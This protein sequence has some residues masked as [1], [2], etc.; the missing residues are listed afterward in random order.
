[1]TILLT[2][3][4]KKSMKYLILL[5]FLSQPLMT[6]PIFYDD[7]TNFPDGWTLY[8]NYGF[9][10]VMRPEGHSSP[11]CS[12][13]CCSTDYY[14]HGEDIYMERSIDLSNCLSASL[15]FWWMVMTE[16]T[17]DFVEL[18]YYTSSWIGAWRESGNYGYSWFQRTV[19][20]PVDATAIRFWFWSDYSAYGHGVFIDDVLLDAA[21]IGIEESNRRSIIEPLVIHIFPNPFSDRMNIQCRVQD[22]QWETADISLWVFDVSGKKIKDLSKELTSGILS[23]S[24]EVF[25]YGDDDTGRKLPAGVYICQLILNSAGKTNGFTATKKIIK[26]K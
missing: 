4:I 17:Y 18:Q 23:H 11:W 10:W 6:E 9:H 24:P 1:M 12:A 21:I 16:A 5:F 8:G 25:W 2:G 26:L 13:A 3:F 15:S 19:D 7:M 22:A 20:I 14:S